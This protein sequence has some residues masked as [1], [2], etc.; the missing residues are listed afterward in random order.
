[1]K[2]VPAKQNDR[3]VGS[4]K[5]VSASSTTSSGE[6]ID[7]PYGVNPTGLLTYFGMAE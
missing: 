2:E 4:W 7:N 6:R 1:M 3:V 5:L